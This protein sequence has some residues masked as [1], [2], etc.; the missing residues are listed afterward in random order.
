MKRKLLTSALCLVLLVFM[1]LSSTLAWFTDSASNVNTMTVGKISIEQTEDFDS[2]ATMMPTQE[3]RKKVTVTND[4]DQAC[5]ARTL[6]AF[7]DSEDGSVLNLV[8]RKTADGVTITITNQKFTVTKDGVTTIYT[9]GYYEHPVAL[10]KDTN[11][12]ALESITLRETATMEW[13][14]QVGD[15]YEILV[16]SQAVQVTGMGNNPTAALNNESVFGQITAE[17]AAKWFK[18]VLESAN[19][20]D[21]TIAAYVN[22]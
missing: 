15:K 6:F 20:G 19:Y 5:Y 17:N 10:T 21:F 22:P 1:L 7:E 11:Y 14:K 4:G 3:I 13:Q 16:L 2:A 12:V 9:V 8:N 18:P